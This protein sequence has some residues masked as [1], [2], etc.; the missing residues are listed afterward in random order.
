M[1]RP[2]IEVWLDLAQWHTALLL[3]ANPVSAGIHE[4]SVQQPAHAGAERQFKLN[5]GECTAA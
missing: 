1:G 2:K 5:V 4:S 3:G